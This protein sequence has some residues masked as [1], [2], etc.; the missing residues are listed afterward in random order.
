[1][2]E[3]QKIMNQFANPNYQE[4]AEKAFTQI[5]GEVAD[6]IL[7]EM[8]ESDEKEI[9]VIS[10][11]AIYKALGNRFQ[12]FTVGKDEHGKDIPLMMYYPNPS[13]GIN[14]VAQN[15]NGKLEAKGTML[16]LSHGGRGNFFEIMKD[17]FRLLPAN[18]DKLDK[19]K[20]QVSKFNS[21]ANLLFVA[22]DKSE[23]LPEF[24]RFTA[25]ME[26]VFNAVAMS[27]SAKKEAG[28]EFNEADYE[29]HAINLLDLFGEEEQLPVEKGLDFYH[30][31]GYYY[32]NTE[33]ALQK[34]EVVV[35]YEMAQTLGKE[36]TQTTAEVV[37][38]IR[39]NPSEDK[40]WDAR[41]LNQGKLTNAL[42]V[43][44]ATLNEFEK[45]GAQKFDAI[46]GAMI[47]TITGK[48]ESY[49]AAQ[50]GFRRQFVA[51][52]SVG[53]IYPSLE[54]AYDLPIVLLTEAEGVLLRDYYVPAI[55]PHDMRLA[56]D[57]HNIYY[58]SLHYDYQSFVS[59]HV[60]SV[61][62]YLG[63]DAVRAFLEL[64]NYFSMPTKH[65]G[66]FGLKYQLKNGKDRIHIAGIVVGS[67]VDGV[68]MTNALETVEPLSPVNWA[69]IDDVSELDENL[70]ALTALSRVGSTNTILYSIAE[71]AETVQVLD[72]TSRLLLVPVVH[73]K[74]EP[75]FLRSEERIFVTSINSHS[76]TALDTGLTVEEYGLYTPVAK[77]IENIRALNR[78][79]V[80][81]G[82]GAFCV[83]N[84][85]TGR[86]YL[87][88]K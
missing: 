72:G 82:I 76:Y 8:T 4:E 15:L 36:E 26:S 48:G 50:E 9:T 84:N 88:I 70:V 38:A 28:I 25:N 19:T 43:N 55:K 5:T 16:A 31:L 57:N 65:R 27:Q 14:A 73:L 86:Y 24:S 54:N 85:E 11:E 23:P 13:V 1:M 39:P 79:A 46:L 22:V 75:D 60:K 40:E 80:F 77:A 6:L 41:L 35:S 64:D 71:N 47:Q 59:S 21:K 44:G 10:T 62:E 69:I 3:A 12:S 45:A 67:S 30:D 2:N 20:Y 49:G 52:V 81:V 66:E 51:P 58:G 68:R 56:V 17:D 78:D 7:K 29:I 42:F 34:S 37:Q 63:I 32:L 87:A 74:D 53:S 61:A 83:K 33:L 18:F